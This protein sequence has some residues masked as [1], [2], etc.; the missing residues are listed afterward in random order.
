MQ[1]L[2]ED[3]LS[4][5]RL[6]R[7]PDSSFVFN[8]AALELEQRGKE[9][10]PA[11]EQAIQERVSPAGRSA[12]NHHELLAKHQ[13]LMNLWMAYIAIAGADDQGRVVRF[14]NSLDGLTLS[15]AI[16]ALRATWPY[17]E[18]TRI[19]MPRTY[20]DFVREVAH[21]TGCSAEVAS[22]LISC[23]ILT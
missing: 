17:D 4:Y 23:L 2:I 7:L 16:L 11:I 18:G 20:L 8:Q 15:T 5:S 13:G 10:L 12:A 22:N 21:G 1:Q 14:L 3:T 9:A 19:A 6:H